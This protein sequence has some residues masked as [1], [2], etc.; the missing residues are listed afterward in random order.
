MVKEG[1][2]LPE[3]GEAHD[4]DAG[5]P[6]RAYD[7]KD[8][9]PLDT[10]IVKAP[11]MG[12]DTN[13]GGLFL[14]TESG[15]FDLRNAYEEP[16]VRPRCEIET[17]N[18]TTNIKG[19]PIQYGLK[20]PNPKYVMIIQIDYFEFKEVELHA[21]TGSHEHQRYG[22]EIY[23]SPIKL[24][25]GLFDHTAYELPLRSQLPFLGPDGDKALCSPTAEWSVNFSLGTWDGRTLNTPG[26]V[27]LNWSVSS[28]AGTDQGTLV[29]SAQGGQIS[30]HSTQGGYRC[31][32]VPDYLWDRYKQVSTVVVGQVRRCLRRDYYNAHLDEFPGGYGG[33]I[34]P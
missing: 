19:V 28:D 20:I 2:N 18:D 3:D 17:E 25:G 12:F 21:Y 11:N 13:R 31:Y 27:T 23:D 15:G 9:D 33:C 16:Q 34:Y 24:T 8:D 30:I 7:I 5:T 1:E 6:A 26:V 29:Y 22:M 10:E 14:S 32:D 4:M